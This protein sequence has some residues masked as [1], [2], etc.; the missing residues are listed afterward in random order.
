L[1]CPQDQ[2]PGLPAFVA[3]PRPVQETPPGP[4]GTQPGAAGGQGRAGWRPPGGARSP[5]SRAAF[6]P[7]R[8]AQP[9]RLARSRRRTGPPRGRGRN[10]AR[11]VLRPGWL[12]A[13]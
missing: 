12:P 9:G 8:T 13:G 6:R 10:A 7:G 3:K 1:A 2:I 4:A 11:S 5:W